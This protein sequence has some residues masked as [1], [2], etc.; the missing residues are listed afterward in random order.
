VVDASHRVEAGDY[1]ELV[2]WSETRHLWRWVL[3]V[4][5]GKTHVGWAET[6]QAALLALALAKSPNPVAHNVRG[7]RHRWERK[8]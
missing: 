7:P 5:G 4:E 2:T 1:R 6:R 8:D 3:V